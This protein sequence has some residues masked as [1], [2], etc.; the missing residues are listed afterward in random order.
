M[1][2]PGYFAETP[3][4]LTV[5][6][7]PLVGI[8][9]HGA[10]DAITGVL[11]LV[12][13]PQ[14]RVGSHRQFV[15]LARQLA[16][17]GMPVMRFDL[18]GMGDAT[19][20][21]LDFS[22]RAPDISAALDA[23]KAHCP[24]LQGVVLWGLCDGA[25]AALLCAQHDARVT[26]MVLLNPWVYSE[27]GA[28]RT[29]LKH[30]YWQRMFSRAAWKGLCQRRLAF[31]AAIAALQKVLRQAAKPR[32]PSPPLAQQMRT[33]LQQF[34]GPVLLILSGRDLTADQFR[35]T[36]EADPI[37]QSLLQQPRIRQHSLTEADHTFSCAAWRDQVAQWTYQWLQTL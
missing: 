27:Q 8:I 16:A 25:S 18:R 3:V 5:Q 28:A 33:G 10:D 20:P 1:V 4:V 19:G 22:E 13:G 15:L 24:A 12:G 11:V 29:L 34:A 36:V 23:F 26:G 6:Q 32:P 21:A 35:D 37:W 31:T 30:Y 2:R 17:Q 7:Q 9:H 14:Y